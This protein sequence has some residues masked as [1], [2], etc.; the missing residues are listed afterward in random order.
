MARN[1]NAC[2]F[3]GSE[4]SDGSLFTAR[5]RYATVTAMKRDRIFNPSDVAR[6]LRSGII[7][8]PLALSRDEI[9]SRSGVRGQESGVGSQ[10]SGGLSTSP[11]R[12]TCKAVGGVLLDLKLI[13]DK[14]L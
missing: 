12:Q 2:G 5:D 3:F 8:S 4:A 11:L 10:G 1:E 6:R 13:L 7:L 14:C 9:L